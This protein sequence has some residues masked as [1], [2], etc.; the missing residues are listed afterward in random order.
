MQAVSAAP[1]IPTVSPGAEGAALP[2]LCAQGQNWAGARMGGEIGPQRPEDAFI[3]E[4]MHCRGHPK[5]QLLP[6]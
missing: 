3:G 6:F 1:R 5:D 2:S 4:F